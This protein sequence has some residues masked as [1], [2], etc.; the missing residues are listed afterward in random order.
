MREV[1]IIGIG[2]TPVGEHW[3]KSIREIAGEAVLAALNDARRD[4]VDAIY[5]GNMMSGIISQQENLGALIA[6]WA[7]LKNIEAI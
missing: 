2:Q 3:E 6:D 1:A 7:G 4:S 5:V